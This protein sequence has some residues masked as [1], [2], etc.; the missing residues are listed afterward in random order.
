MTQ[1]EQITIFVMGLGAVIGGFYYLWNIGQSRTIIK[2]EPYVAVFPPN[3]AETLGIKVINESHHAV[4]LTKI[5]ILFSNTEMRM[6]T[7]IP[8]SQDSK[9]LPHRIEPHS[10]FEGTFGP[11]LYKTE[12][13][14]VF[15][16]HVYAQISNGK[17]YRKEIYFNPAKERAGA[18]L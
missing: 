6:T 11:G 10:S 18:K 7:P 16:T 12:P 2:V 8:I 3:P 1:A 14:M 9:P 15:A 13:N 5:G 17:I 4:T